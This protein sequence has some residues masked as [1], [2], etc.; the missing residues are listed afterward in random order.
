[1]TTEQENKLLTHLQKKHK[2]FIHDVKTGRHLH[3]SHK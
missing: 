1:M 3:V 2:A